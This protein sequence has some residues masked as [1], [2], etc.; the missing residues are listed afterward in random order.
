MFYSG[1]LS[2][3]LGARQWVYQNRDRIQFEL[4]MRFPIPRNYVKPVADSFLYVLVSVP[5]AIALN[6]FLN[7]RAV[8]GTI[9]YSMAIAGFFKMADSYNGRQL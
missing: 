4:T 1:L 2:C 6:W 7:Q 9:L 8:R 5:P 3:Y